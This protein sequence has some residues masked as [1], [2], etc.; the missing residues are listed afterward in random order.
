MAKFEIDLAGLIINID[1]EFDA[2]FKIYFDQ[3][4]DIPFRRWLAVFY[5]FNADL[6]SEEVIAQMRAE[7]SDPHL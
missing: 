1:F 5:P 4:F 3:S 6:E 2:S 7:S